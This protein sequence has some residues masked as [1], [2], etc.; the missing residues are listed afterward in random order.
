MSSRDGSVPGAKWRARSTSLSRLASPL[1]TD[2]NTQRAATPLARRLPS[3]P[4]RRRTM[5]AISGGR[6]SA[7]SRKRRMKSADE[8]LQLFAPLG[9]DGLQPVPN[10]FRHHDGEK[11]DV[12]H[13][14]P[15]LRRTGSLVHKRTCQHFRPPSSGRCPGQLASALLRQPHPGERDQLLRGRGFRAP[16]YAA[17]DPFGEGCRRASARPRRSRPNGSSLSGARRPGG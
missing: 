9:R 8:V 5:S 6:R 11:G 13:V 16:R 15:C 17:L 3:T 14:F 10:A 1:A 2:P 12:V 4:R 7:S